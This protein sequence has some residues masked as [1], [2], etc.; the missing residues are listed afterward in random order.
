MTCHHRNCNQNRCHHPHHRRQYQWWI[1]GY[2][3]TSVNYLNRFIT[4]LWALM[5][6]V[7][8]S[9]VMFIKSMRVWS[10]LT[11]W[12]GKHWKIISLHSSYEDSQSLIGL[13]ILSVFILLGSGILSV[14]ISADINKPV[15]KPTNQGLPWTHLEASN[16]SMVSAD[17]HARFSLSLRLLSK[18]ISSIN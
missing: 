17:H 14:F 15:E 8:Y 12:N 7:L 4:V 16:D 3:S 11:T 1:G 13:G 10:F 2:Y 5:N 18:R 6:M 9:M